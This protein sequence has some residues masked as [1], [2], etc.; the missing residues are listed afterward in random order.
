MSLHDPR[1]VR[2]PFACSER[3]REGVA[4]LCHRLCK[5]GFLIFCCFDWV[6]SNPRVDTLLVLY[7]C[8]IASRVEPPLTS[9]SVHL[10]VRNSDCPKAFPRLWADPPPAHIVA[11]PACAQAWSD[12]KEPWHS[13]V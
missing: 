6:P 2:M 13:R 11:H 7:L 4:N 5:F 1:A 3:E 8:F 10:H 9:C 12:P